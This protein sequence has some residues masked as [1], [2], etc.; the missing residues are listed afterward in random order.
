MIKRISK[1]K[2][3]GLLALLLLTSVY[4]MAQEAVKPDTAIPARRD[5][6][7]PAKADT[8]IRAKGND[9]KQLKQINERKTQ[10]HSDSAG[11]EPKKSELIDTTTHN[12][13][14]D[15][16][17]DDPEYNK[18]YHIWIPA[19]E[20]LGALA[21]TWSLDRY[22]LNADYAR[23][24]FNS[25]KYNINT[26]WEWDT[27]RFGVNFIGHP[28]SGTLSFNAGRSNG[29]NYFQSFGYGHRRQPYVGIFRGKY[30]TL[31]Q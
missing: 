4:L 6:T 2:L 29:Y 23:T 30:T 11:N 17:N 3:T 25:W 1:I 12:K 18:K 31:L 8:V 21:F 20:V 14:G 13:Y 9:D 22:G 16:L 5:T 24:G 7:I 26:G 27:D 19:V 10:L 28:Y 15:L